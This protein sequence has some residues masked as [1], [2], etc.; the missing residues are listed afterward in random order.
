MEQDMFQLVIVGEA[1][2]GTTATAGVSILWV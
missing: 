2:E 1:G